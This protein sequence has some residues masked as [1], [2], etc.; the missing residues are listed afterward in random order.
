M[1]A[2]A[3]A[4]AMDGLRLQQVGGAVHRAL[5]R[6]DNALSR[7]LAAPSRH[8]CPRTRT[9]QPWPRP[10]ATSVRNAGP[11]GGRRSARHRVVANFR[12][13]TRTMNILPGSVA[14]KLFQTVCV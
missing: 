11:E 8:L 14:D 7:I 1:D 2:D 13:S 12:Q 10:A 4:D 3:P 6:L 9:G 5:R